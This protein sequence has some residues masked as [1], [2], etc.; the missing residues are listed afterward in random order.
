MKLTDMNATQLERLYR[1][2]HQ[3]MSAG[4]GYQ[5]WGHDWVTMR[6]TKPGWY[7]TLRSILKAWREVEATS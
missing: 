4:D 2:A 3:R 6:I 5:P 1:N 7:V